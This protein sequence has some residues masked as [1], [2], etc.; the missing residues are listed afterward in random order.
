MKRIATLFILTLFVIDSYSQTKKDLAISLTGGFLNSPYYEKAKAN[1][2]YTIGFDYYIS[3][4]HVLSVNYLS[5]S[6]EYFD[7]IQSNTSGTISANGTNATAVYETFS[8][9]YKYK[10]LSQSK[11]SILPSVGAG[12]MTHTKRFP[13]SI[14]NS[15]LIQTSSWSDLVFPIDLDIDFEISKH[16]QLG[17]TG[18]F[19]IH[20]D[21]P[22]LALHVGP[23]L[24]YVIK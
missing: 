14:G 19:Q 2:F 18:G 4:R 1:G 3:Q 15:T 21:F 23:R 6:H 16:W 5:G 20:P 9:S 22:I 24:S 13:Y 7:N 12:I 11:I 10:I 8:V 17:I